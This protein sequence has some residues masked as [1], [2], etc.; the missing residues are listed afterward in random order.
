[1]FSPAG[2]IPEDPVTGSAHSMLGS[3]WKKKFQDEGESTT[4]MVGRQVSARGGEVGVRLDRQKNVCSLRGYTRLVAK[5]ELYL[6]SQVDT[7]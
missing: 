3:Y 4:E 1:M 7:L 5:G 6:P 2:G